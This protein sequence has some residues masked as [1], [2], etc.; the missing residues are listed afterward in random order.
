MPVL[1]IIYVAV[2]H[3]VMTH[4]LETWVTTLRIGR[5]LGGFH[6]S[7]SHR[8]TGRQPWRGQDGGWVYPTM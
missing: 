5:V 8:L 6:H 1:G 7:V 4:G 3:G 2:V